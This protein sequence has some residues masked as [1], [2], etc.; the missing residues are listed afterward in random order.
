M[1]LRPPAAAQPG[2]GD[3]D[4][5][6]LFSTN[7]SG[8]FS[9]GQRDLSR[10]SFG[11][12]SAGFTSRDSRLDSL[13]EGMPLED[14]PFNLSSLRVYTCCVGKTLSQAEYSIGDEEQKRLHV[15]ALFISGVR[16]A[17]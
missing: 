2:G 10:G 3:K 8:Y 1:Q 14:P 17:T 12:L 5:D 16:S 13:S 4:F 15:R 9:K 6:A 7:V 11:S